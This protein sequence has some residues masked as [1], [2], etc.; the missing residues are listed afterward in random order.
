MT[1][2]FGIP[3]GYKSRPQQSILNLISGC[4]FSFHR[5]FVTACW[6]HDPTE[7]TWSPS[8]CFSFTPL[9]FLPSLKSIEL[10][11]PPWPL[12]TSRR[13]LETD[14]GPALTH[15][16]AFHLLQ[17]N[18]NWL[19]IF[20]YHQ[21]Q[22]NHSK[23]KR[24]TCLQLGSRTNTSPPRPILFCMCRSSSA[25]KWRKNDFVI[26]SITRSWLKRCSFH[27]LP[28]E[29]GKPLVPEWYFGQAS[30]ISKPPVGVII[31]AWNCRCWKVIRSAMV[32]LS[33]MTLMSRISHLTTGK[34]KQ[35]K[36]SRTGHSALLWMT[37]FYLDVSL[38]WGV[39]KRLEGETKSPQI[40]LHGH[41]GTVCFQ[42]LFFER[43]F[44]LRT[45]CTMCL[46]KQV[47]S[48]IMTSRQQG[49][50]FV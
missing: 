28:C 15:S 7:A 16:N 33:P 8:T 17:V 9:P 49:L 30:S 14:E 20:T 12:K 27:C 18:S 13:R 10:I 1:S 23:W 31:A 41:V 43:M 48:I 42:D 47:W 36:H 34:I 24:R 25:I 21:M 26:K 32:S 5:P 22:W 19:V 44:Q 35:H 2:R 45:P 11:F 3:R 38:I 37:S 4:S 50:L 39:W 40:S 6:T 46:H 29:G